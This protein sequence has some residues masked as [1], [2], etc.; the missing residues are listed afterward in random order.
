[1]P[2]LQEQIPK[3]RKHRASGQAIS[4]INGRTFY[5]GPHGTKASRREYDRIVAEWLTAGRSPAYGHSD[6]LVTIS[7]VVDQ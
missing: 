7:Q 4:K 2:R 3:Y 6:S 5:L 1:M